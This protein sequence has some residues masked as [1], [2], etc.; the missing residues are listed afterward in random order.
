[1]RIP[2]I[3][4]LTVLVIVAGLGGGAYYRIR[5][6]T[7]AEA[8]EGGRPLAGRERTPSDVAIPVEGAAARRDTLVV[9]LNAAG[10]AAAWRQMVV[11]APVSGRVARLA[12]RESQGVGA[13]A[14]LVQLDPVEPQ[15]AVAE[16]EARLRSAQVQYREL[17]LLNDEIGS[18]AARVERE[19]F[20]RARS[21]LDEAQVSLRKAQVSLDRTRLAA[22]FAGR[23]ASVNVV[24]G[25]WVSP[26]TEL[27]TVLSLDPIKVEV[28]VLEGEIGYLGEGGSAGI[29]FGALPGETFGGRI[30]SINPL[31]DPKTRTARVTVLVPNPRGRVLPGMYARVSM[32]AR[33]YPDRVLVPRAA[34]VERD[35]RSVVFVLANEDGGTRARWRYVTTGLANDS[36]VEIV[37]NPRTDSVRPGEVVLTGGHHTL[38]H[39][40]R[41]KRV[42]DADRAAER[43]P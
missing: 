19:R 5:G 2:L 22:P 40:A 8:A 17:T 41:V 43:E 11:T 12:A 29:T 34:V 28:Q 39:N 7:A 32:Q 30:V 36:L 13:G 38:I 35:R 1:M 14:D 37:P 27:L 24:P 18:D 3:R 6:A 33:R 31:V 20:A 9:Y 21:G 26:G 15:L 42:A 23:V 10:Q 16:A 25:Q 4:A